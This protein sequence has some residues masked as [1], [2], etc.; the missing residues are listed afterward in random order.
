[1]SSPCTSAVLNVY[2]LILCVNYC[3]AC[4]SIQCYVNLV[5]VSA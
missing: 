1:M 3:V 2:A 5:T 4:V